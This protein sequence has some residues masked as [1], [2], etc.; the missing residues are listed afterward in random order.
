MVSVATKAVYRQEEKVL[1]AECN[2]SW[3]FPRS[4][5]G[6]TKENKRIKTEGEEKWEKPCLGPCQSGGQVTSAYRGDTASLITNVDY[7]QI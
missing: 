7:I 5:V 1:K 6:K 4:Q 2:L 3:V